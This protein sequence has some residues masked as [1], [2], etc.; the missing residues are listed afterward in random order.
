MAFLN[1]QIFCT[2]DFLTQTREWDGGFNVYRIYIF[3]Y[4]FVFLLKKRECCRKWCD[5]FN[6]DA[7]FEHLLRLLAT[8][9]VKKYSF[10]SKNKWIIDISCGYCLTDTH[11]TRHTSNEIAAKCLN[12]RRAL[13]NNLIHVCKD[14]RYNVS[15]SYEVCLILHLNEKS[16]HLFSFCW[17]K[18]VDL[19]IKQT[20]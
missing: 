20:I 7:I 11:K 12:W 13:N 15:N 1:W 6:K 9:A 2:N 18:D 14:R 10:F 19:R 4:I 5:R 17:F 16:I 3:Y 8:L